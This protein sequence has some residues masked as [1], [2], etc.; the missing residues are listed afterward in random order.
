MAAFGSP[1]IVWLGTHRYVFPPNRDVTIGSNSGADIQLYGLGGLSEPQV[2]LHFNGSE[3]IAVDRS[4]AG[5]YVDG[6]RM[7]TVFIHDGRAIAF[8]DPQHGPRLVFQLPPR[9]PRRR[10]ASRPPPMRPAAHRH[11]PPPPPSRPALSATPAAAASSRPPPPPRPVQRVASTTTTAT[12]PPA[13]P[14]T[15]ATAPPPLRRHRLPANDGRARRRHAAAPPPPPPPPPAQ[16][17]RADRLHA[18]RA[19]RGWPP[20]SR[21]QGRNCGS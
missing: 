3:W 6:V 2:L 4:E 17:E 13:V 15:A 19:S 7:S 8:G 21:S 16:P 5:M 1:L 9:L 12:G 20:G 10:R 11:H 18:A 14:S